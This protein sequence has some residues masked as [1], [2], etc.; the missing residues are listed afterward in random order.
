MKLHPRR[1]ELRT[2]LSSSRLPDLPPA[3]REAINRVEATVMAP[4]A[5]ARALDRYRRF[6]KQPGRWLTLPDDW[7]PCPLE[8]PID[9][10]DELEWILQQM[11]RRGRAALAAYVARLDA[12]LRRRTLPDPLAAKRSTWA[13]EHWWRQR[14]LSP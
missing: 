3:A 12:I 5:V 11:P 14:L 10:R 6:L 9:A 4:G 8:D 13:A 7:F 1:H 2:L